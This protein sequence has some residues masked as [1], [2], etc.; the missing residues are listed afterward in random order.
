MLLWTAF[1]AG[2]M[3]SFHCV[4]MCGPIALALPGRRPLD[5][6]LYQ[7]G[8]I[9]TYALLGAVVG[10]VGR[11]AA[12]LGGGRWVALAAGTTLLVSALLTLGG[13]RRTGAVRPLYRLTGHLQKHLRRYLRRDS[14]VAAWT[15]GMLNGLLPCGLVWVALAAGTTLLVSA[16]LTL[17]GRRR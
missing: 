14:F 3:G 5:R 7:A 1:L 12:L 15:L 11:G 16:L 4:G 8:R 13:R 10:G 17:G 9:A 2:A 6:M